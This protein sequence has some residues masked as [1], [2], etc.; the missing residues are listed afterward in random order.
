[1]G[2]GREERGREKG[3][4]RD[5]GRAGEKRE[6]GRQIGREGRM[7]KERHSIEVVAQ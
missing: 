6:E 4:E 2:G 1:M 3:G 5:A 7:E